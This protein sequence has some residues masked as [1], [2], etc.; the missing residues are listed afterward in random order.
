MEQYQGGW[1][2]ISQAI[3]EHIHLMMERY[4]ETG[5]VFRCISSK[6]GFFPYSQCLRKVL[7]D[8]D[9]DR[10]NNFIVSRKPLARRVVQKSLGR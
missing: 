5:N 3:D 8:K 2:E 7:A 9:W 6:I 1:E 10:L 4:L